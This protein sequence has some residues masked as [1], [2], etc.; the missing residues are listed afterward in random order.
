MV[1]DSNFQS[2]AS[3]SNGNGRLLPAESSRFNFD[4]PKTSEDSVNFGKLLSILHRRWLWLIIA[5]LLVST[6]IWTKVLLQEPRYAS[7]FQLLVGSPTGENRYLNFDQDGQLK[8]QSG[9]ENLDYDTQIQVLFSP[10][11]LTPILENISQQ[12]PDFDYGNFFQYLKVYRL[13]NTKIL[14]VTYQ[15]G[16]P[17]TVKTVL[18]E[19]AQG[20]VEYSHNQQQSSLNQ[21]LKFT[22]EQLP[23]LQ[24]RVDKLQEK[25]QRF[26]QKNDLIE[27]A[28]KAESLSE[29]LNSVIE[30]RQETDTQLRETELL[31]GRI[32]EQLGLGL[33]QAMEVA[34]LSEAPRYQSLLTQLQEVE[35]Q[36]ALESA[37]FT[38]GSP[39]VSRLYEQR[40]NLLPLLNR[41]ASSVLGD[42][43]VANVQAL[44]ASTNPIRLQL[45]QNLIEVANQRQVLLTRVQSL[46]AVENQFRQQLKEMALLVRQY[47]DLQRELQ[48]ANDSLNHFL[49]AQDTLQIEASQQT[50]SWQLLA[51]PKL[52]TAPFAPNRP[53]GWLIGGIAGIMAGVGAALLAEK[54]DR[55]FH[56]PEDIQELARLPVVGRIPFEQVLKSDRNRQ[57]TSVNLISDSHNNSAVLDAFRSLHAN[58]YMLNPDRH[59]RSLVISSPVPEEGKSTTAVCLAQASAAMGQR[60]LLVDAD[61]RRPRI[62]VMTDVPNVWGLSDLIA[63]DLDHNDVIQQSPLEDNLHILTAGQNPP[64][65]TRLLSSQKMRNLMEELQ[66][67]FD[68]VIFDTPPLLGL[69]DAKLI[70]PQTDGLALVVSLGRSDRSAL[71]QVLEGIKMSNLSVLGMI[72]NRVKYYANQ[73]PEY[74]QRYYTKTKKSGNQANSKTIKQPKSS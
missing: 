18:D 27:P 10:K 56:S 19:I 6:G 2:I 45:T 36:L 61:L 31:S 26:R 74:Y 39:L 46:M 14:E 37:R 67:S 54:L 7:K 59:L 25:L 12:V 53:R 29:L 43:S 44:A 57:D 8:S 52:P 3:H 33:E 65:P 48:V 66:T 13:G 40:Q 9:E 35:T 71:K 64:D 47:T 68:L 22:Q 58:L 11:V 70:V 1:S 4:L 72:A 15:D 38:E 20:Y 60:V 69:V 23:V 24:A 49:N 34:A 63:G 17:Q 30:Q 16:D 21:G 42:T 51:D 5:S 41:E 62:H 28:I 32:Q 50:S 73:Y 55:R